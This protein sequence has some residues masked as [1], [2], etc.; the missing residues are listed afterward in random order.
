MSNQS[1]VYGYIETE[2]DFDAQN[3][4]TLEKWPW[5]R[6]FPKL[7]SSPQPGFVGSVI[8][9]GWSCNHFS[10]YLPE[11][12]LTFERLIHA[13]FAKEAKIHCSDECGVLTWC[14]SYICLD[15]VVPVPQHRR[16]KR[17]RVDR[18]LRFGPEEILFDKS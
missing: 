1:I 8:A 5:T 3:T 13:L 14:F 15:P 18:E 11:W 12:Q 2:T 9:F 10:H 7:F 16:W 4:A 6:D 17:W